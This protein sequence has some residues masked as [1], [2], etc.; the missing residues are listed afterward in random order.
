[1]TTYYQYA[2]ML[3]VSTLVALCA[4]LCGIGGAAMFSPIFLLLFPLLGLQL[5][6]PPAGRGLG[7]PH[8]SVWICLRAHWL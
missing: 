1:M 5:H 3:P 6:S 7:P 4:Q 8:R 2:F